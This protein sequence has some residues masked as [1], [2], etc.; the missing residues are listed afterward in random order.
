V[1]DALARGGDIPGQARSLVSLAW[2]DGRRDALVTAAA[3]RELEGF[4]D[5]AIPALRDAL[6][7][8][9]PGDTAE[10]LATALGAQRNSRAEMASEYIAMLVDALWVGSREA[11]ILAI[12]GIFVAQTPFAVQPLI[13]SALDDPELAAPVVELLGRMHFPQSR[14]YL[15][16]VMME[17]PAA[18]RPAAAASLAQIGGAALA[19]LRNALKA[20]SRDARLLA[21]RALLP[22]ATEYDLGAIYEYL[23]KHGDD[24][25][26]LTKALKASAANI[27][28]AI[29]ARDANA[30]AGSPRDF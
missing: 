16:S 19:P 4:G 1:L 22:S 25:A 13:D 15:E 28:K 10:V 2:P 20:P 21:G 30:A 12:G 27:E 9:K 24:D 6:N 29:A 26:N 11:K 23:E 8:V 18:L 3:R 14:F 7:A 5:H 17:G